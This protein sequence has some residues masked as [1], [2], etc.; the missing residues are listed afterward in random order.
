MIEYATQQDFM[1]IE[2]YVQLDKEIKKE[3]TNADQV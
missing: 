1:D 2:T 3:A